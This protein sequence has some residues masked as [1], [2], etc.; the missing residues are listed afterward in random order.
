MM[1][2]E[3]VPAVILSGGE[4]RRMGRNDK[5]FLSIEDKTLLEITLERL[6]RQ[7]QQIAINTN[8]NDP[9]YLAYNL[10]V[11]NDAISGFLGPLAGIFTAMK[12]ANQMGYKSVATIAV[13]TPL[14]PENLLKKLHRK[15]EMSNSDIVFA[16]TS[17]D[18]KKKK[19][20]HPVFGLWK[21]SLYNDLGKELESG[22]R[23]VTHWSERHKASN[24]FFQDKH[25]D[26]FF[27]VNSPED[28][29]ILREHYRKK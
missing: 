22:V 4:S 29:A 11:L 1:S 24:V 14:F 6:H 9:K 27:N 12:W 8:S 10:P 18:Y 19:L 5:A 28:I 2:K 15:M 25:L 16:G 20:L 17:T 13:D 3:E 7:T 26:P 21:T 23:K